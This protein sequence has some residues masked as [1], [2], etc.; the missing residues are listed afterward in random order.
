[1][2]T[3]YLGISIDGG[4]SQTVTGFLQ[5]DYEH[6]WDGFPPSTASQAISSGLTIVEI[7]LR[8]KF[9]FYVGTMGTYNVDM[10]DKSLFQIT[11]QQNTN[12]IS[13]EHILYDNN[14]NL[15]SSSC[16]NNG[17]PGSH[18]NLDVSVG[19]ILDV[20]I[21]NYNAYSGNVNVTAGYS[22]PEN[23]SIGS[24]TTFKKVSTSSPIY[25]SI[26]IF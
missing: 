10:S 11:M 20:G 12:R 2:A 3:G 18:Q 25:V 16:A 26:G 23:F 22:N 5:Y 19:D 9:K 1:M 7:T 4:T 24:H 15:V 21:Y 8:D 17:T 14:G 6:D 13:G